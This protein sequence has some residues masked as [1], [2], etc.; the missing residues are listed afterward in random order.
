M[1]S[2]FYCTCDRDCE[3]LGVKFYKDRLYCIDQNYVCHFFEVH[4]MDGNMLGY[5]NPYELD[6][7]FTTVMFIINDIDKMFNKI[8]DYGVDMH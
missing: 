6:S 4:D 2:K 7:C 1:G 8:M 5:V 3:I